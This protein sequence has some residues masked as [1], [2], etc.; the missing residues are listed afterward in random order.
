MKFYEATI[1]LDGKQQERFESLTKRFK[2]I[3]EWNGYE[4]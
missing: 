2:E 4:Q 1:I 3:N